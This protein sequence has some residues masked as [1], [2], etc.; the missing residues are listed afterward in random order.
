MS[1]VPTNLHLE[2]YLEVE[3]IT[4]FEACRTPCP[5]AGHKGYLFG[6]DGKYC[7]VRFPLPFTCTKG[8]VWERS[9]D[10]PYMDLKFEEPEI[11]LF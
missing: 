7:R 11:R 9:F 10:A 8:Y 2:D 3:I 1:T 4:P 5:P 6:F